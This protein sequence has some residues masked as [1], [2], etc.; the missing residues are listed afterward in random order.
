MERNLDFEQSRA[1]Q[2]RV[3]IKLAGFDF[4]LQ[5]NEYAWTESNFFLIGSHKVR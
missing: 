5:A 3:Q 2:S 1:G 4:F